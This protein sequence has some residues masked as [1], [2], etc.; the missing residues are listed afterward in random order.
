MRL[1]GVAQ[2]IDALNGRVGRRIK[3]DAVIRAGDVVVDRAGRPTT[4]MPYFDRASAP[5]NVPSP[6][7]A[8]MPSSP[9]SLQVLTA[10]FWPSSVRNSSLRAV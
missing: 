6:P 5:R 1:H 8:T 10:F 9:R 2:L 4:E 3:A 7:M